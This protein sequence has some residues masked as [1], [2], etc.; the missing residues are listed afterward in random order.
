MSITTWTSR[1][2]SSKKKNT[3]FTLR[4]NDQF[5]KYRTESAY[6]QLACDW[7]HWETM[8]GKTQAINKAFFNMIRYD[9][10]LLFLSKDLC[11]IILQYIFSDHSEKFTELKRQRIN[12]LNPVTLNFNWN[13]LNN[14][15]SSPTSKKTLKYPL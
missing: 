11:S 14:Y 5:C 13:F 8:K 15:W 1:I 7:E 2:I 3:D 6:K 12:T 4:N 10:I 9:N